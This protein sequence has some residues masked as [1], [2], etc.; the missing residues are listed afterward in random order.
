MPS[1]E[2]LSETLVRDDLIRAL[3]SVFS[4]SLGLPVRLHEPN[5]PGRCAAPSPAPAPVITQVVGSVGF[6]GELNGVIYLCFEE[7]FARLCTGNMLGLD[8]AEVLE[9]GEEPVNDAIG[10]I[11]N[12]VVGA[13]KNGLCD[14]GFPCKLTI[15]TILRGSNVTIGPI[16][17]VRRH[18]FGFESA[19]HLI[20]ADILMKAGD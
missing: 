4:T 11:T 3:T 16:S 15:P 5:P 13:F 10:E 12:M 9:M 19:G 8:E 6:F 1:A 7:V 17:T 14:A 18:T 2:A 20:V